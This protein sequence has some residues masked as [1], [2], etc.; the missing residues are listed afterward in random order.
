MRYFLCRCLYLCVSTFFLVSQPISG[1]AQSLS[2]FSETKQQFTL[3]PLSD[4]TFTYYSLSPSVAPTQAFILIHGYPHDVKRNIEVEKKLSLLPAFKNTLFI[5]PFFPV[6]AQK[7]NHCSNQLTPESTPDNATWTCQSWMNGGMN[8]QGDVSAFQAMDMLVNHLKSQWPSLTK[9]TIAGFS[10]GAQFTQHYIGFAQIPKHIEVQYI[11]SDPGSWL[12][13]TPERMTNTSNAEQCP[14]INSWKYGMDQLPVHLTAQRTSALTQYKQAH[15]TY[16]IGDNDQLNAKHSSTGRL[17]RTCAA[18]AQ[19]IDR[20][21]RAINYTAYEQKFITPSEPH[22]LYIVPSCSHQVQCVFE[23][24]M[25][26]N[27]LTTLH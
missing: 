2:L 14:N 23:H 15:I 25:I 21:D 16:L 27:I 18:N 24:K 8:D 10:A 13:F 20:R 3:S 6:N 4:N 17:D 5:A 12:Y 26:I 19:G 7:A 9:V 1:N 22:K 11:V